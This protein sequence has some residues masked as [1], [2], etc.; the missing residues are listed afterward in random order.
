MR[1]LAVDCLDECSRSNVIVVRHRDGSKTSTVWLGEMLAEAKTKSLADW[2]A[3]GGPLAAP[4]PSSLA[5]AAF[6]PGDDAICAV[7]K[8]ERASDAVSDVC[9]EL[10]QG[11]FV[12]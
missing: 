4:M 9:R 7:E 5:F 1:V 10:A 8:I 6:A 12:K 3:R 11:C 2:I